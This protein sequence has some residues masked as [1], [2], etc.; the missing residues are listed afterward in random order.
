MATTTNHDGEKRLQLLCADNSGQLERIADLLER[1]SAADYTQTQS[2]ADPIGKHVRHVLE[3][4]EGLLNG[5]PGGAVDYEGRAREPE[6][7]NSPEAARHRLRSLQQ[8]LLELPHRGGAGAL[9]IHYTPQ[10]DEAA[11]RITSTLERELHFLL[12][13]TIHHMALIGLL[14]QHCAQSV[15]S[16]FGVAGSTLRYQRTS[17][18][19]NIDPEYSTQA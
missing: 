3:H 14:A 4:Y 5:W 18:A 12:S 9:L 16:A 11:A 19:E 6:L 1:L 8:R 17:S 10:S 13:H 7:E 15:D 2:A